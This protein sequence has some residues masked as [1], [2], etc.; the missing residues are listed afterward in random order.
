MRRIG[1]ALFF[2]ILVLSH[3]L[4][5][6]A[7][8]A[9]EVYETFS[10]S[11][12]L[13]FASIGEG[14]GMIGTGS[15]ITDS[16]HIITNA[17]VVIDAATG[18]P[19]PNIGISLKPAKVTGNMDKDLENSYPAEV[20]YYSNELDLAL[21]L[22][23]GWSKVADSPKGLNAISLANPEEIKVGEE[24][25]AIGHP[26]QG[27]LWSLTY[28]RISGT[29]LDFQNISGKDVFQTDTNVNRG[30]SGGPLLDG[31]GYMVAVNSNI[32]RVGSG[33]LPI[34]GVNFSIKSSVVKKWLEGL[35]VSIAY[36]TDSSAGVTIKEEAE[37]GKSKAV[38]EDKTVST[39]KTDI[40]S[41]ENQEK[42]DGGDTGRYST[43]SKPYDYEDLLEKLTEELEGDMDEMREKAR[44]IRTK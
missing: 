34:T 10:P 26:E 21:L 35:S 36:G 5:Y 40:K 16:G 15:I 6:A 28:G 22:F 30:N 19:Y 43:P 8:P 2:L 25:I 3:S 14:G 1:A 37:T 44:G 12:V 17:H 18:K 13:V 31:R 32:A 38:S 39:K 23:Q 9:K 41:K 42:N 20:L 4:S 29:I 11:V 24:V 7:F 27:G 33:G